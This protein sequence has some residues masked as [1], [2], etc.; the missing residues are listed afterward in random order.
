MPYPK[1]LSLHTVWDEIA[2][3]LD[4]TKDLRSLALTCRTFK[5]LIIPDHLHY[6]NLSID[7]RTSSFWEFLARRPRLAKSVRSIELSCWVSDRSIPPALS[8]LT[9]TI[10]RDVPVND[11]DIAIF[12]SALSRIPFLKWFYWTDLG[13][14]STE[15]LIAISHTLTASAPFLEGLYV[16]LFEIDA[17]KHDQQQ[18][19]RL[20]I[21]TLTSL[22]RVIL[23]SQCASPDAIQMILSCPNI[24]DLSSGATSDLNRAF[25]FYM[26]QQANWTKLRRLELQKLSIQN[27]EEKSMDIT[28]IITSFFIRHSNI[29]C[30]SFY[31]SSDIALSTLPPSSLPKL[32]SLRSDLEVMTSLLSTSAISRL[33]HLNLACMTT[34]IIAYTVPQMDKLESL[35]LLGEEI[36][37]FDLIDP[38][39][40]KTP[41]LRK[42]KTLVTDKEISTVRRKSSVR[43]WNKGIQRP[44]ITKKH[45]Q[46]HYTEPFLKYPQSKLTHIYIEFADTYDD[47]RF[48][49]GVLCEELS[50]LQDLKYITVDDEYVELERDKNGIYSRYRSISYKK[51]E[52]S[53]SWGGFFP[54]EPPSWNS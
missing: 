39:L 30:L 54:S 43:F 50:A 46:A 22:K 24:E 31:V 21:W 7:I 32:R 38:F 41:N 16:N 28:T 19:K 23:N 52:D 36:N 25:P 40:S 51:A 4:S 18:I 37:G 34:Q 29:E 26:L 49:M 42:I 11:S 44:Y 48:R 8:A 1:G 53:F 13:N 27:E 12:K 9:N 6:R 3:L 35:H 15:Q 17:M 10:P 45:L 33:M 47:V 2:H 14:T 5:E 20:S